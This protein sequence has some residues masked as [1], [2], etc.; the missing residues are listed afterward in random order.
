[1][2]DESCTFVHSR[3][4]W[5][6]GMMGR[7]KSAALGA[8]IALVFLVR[9]AAAPVSAELVYF[10]SGRVMPVAGH[11]V[12]GS[13]IVLSLRG[14][15][16][17][18]CDAGLIDRIELDAPPVTPVPPIRTARPSPLPS[19]PYAELIHRASERHGVAAGLLHALI[20]VESSYRADAE[21]PQG[22]MGLMQLMPATAARYELHDPFDPGANIDAGA[23][24]LRQ[25]L[26][27]FGMQ[28]ALAAYNAGEGSVRK[29]R[30]IPPYPETHH[31]V[32]RI[33]ELAQA[34]QGD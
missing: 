7:M 27:K 19:K 33:L 20:E 8:C 10:A 15:G 5:Q 22:A 34:S 16:E 11:R 3:K 32:S 25:L 31:Y 4:L 9:P 17:V 14:G 23:Q 6:L 13:T 12:E 28:G 21:S 18:I 24:H 29:F 30:G 2:D 1:M 26:D